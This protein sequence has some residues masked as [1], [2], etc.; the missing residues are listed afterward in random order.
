MR[1][2]STA[3]PLDDN[4]GVTVLSFGHYTTFP[5]SGDGG[6]ASVPV[7]SGTARVYYSNV[8]LGAAGGN[9]AVGDVLTSNNGTANYPARFR[10]ESID[11]N[12]GVTGFSVITGG[13]FATPLVS[14]LTTF[15]NRPGG[16]GAT[17]IPH[18]AP[19]FENSDICGGI[20]ILAGGTGIGQPRNVI[21]T[22]NV[23]SN[24]FG[25]YTP[26]ANGILINMLGTNTQGI[27]NCLI[28]QNV[29]SLNNSNSIRVRW[30]GA[31]H[32]ELLDSSNITTPN[33]TAYP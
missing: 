23:C 26:Q 24:T 28:T 20:G 2:I 1:G 6:S 19:R 33:I 12:G 16:S 30:S 17:F 14:P 31:Y 9:Y 18:W 21:I 29:L 10:V 7:N 3:H 27:R 8:R 25:A 22:N 4:N 13:G 15:T 32:P 5:G 11:G